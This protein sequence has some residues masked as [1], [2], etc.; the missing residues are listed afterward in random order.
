MASSALQICLILGFIVLT[1]AGWHCGDGSATE[2]ASTTE[3][4]AD[5]HFHNRKLR[6]NPDEIHLNAVFDKFLC[7]CNSFMCN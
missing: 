7:F 2:R 1:T 3:F 5:L 4:G 6:A